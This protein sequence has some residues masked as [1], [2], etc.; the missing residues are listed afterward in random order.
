MDHGPTLSS[1]PVETWLHRGDHPYPAIQLFI[2]L[3]LIISWFGIVVGGIAGLAS[4]IVGLVAGHGFISFL[5]MLLVW[6]ISIL[7]WIG[8]RVMPE[9]LQVVLQIETHLQALRNA[10]TPK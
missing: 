1:N 2:R 3:A 7:W 5:G 6:A 9:L 8:F 10:S 4:F